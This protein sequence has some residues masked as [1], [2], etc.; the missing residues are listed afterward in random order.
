MRKATLV[1]IVFI[2]VAAA[3]A[4]AQLRL[5]WDACGSVGVKNRDFACNTNAG[6]ER[7]IGSFM[8]P[9]GITALNGQAATLYADFDNGMIPSWWTFGAAPRCRAATSMRSVFSNDGVSGA[10]LWYFP[11]RGVQ[12]AHLPDEAPWWPGRLRIRTVAAIHAEL[13]GP[14]SPDSEQYAFSLSIDH[15]RTVGT[16]A[17]A[18]CTTYGEFWF[19]ELL[20]TQPVGVGDFTLQREWGWD[21]WVS[22]QQHPTPAHGPSWGRLKTLYR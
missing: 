10:C 13:V 19:E 3:D 2:V 17:C 20:L 9:P 1:S 12:G 22:W 21:A 11:E 7:L 15:A 4:S 16:G 14:V 5:T 6:S 8:P 18:G